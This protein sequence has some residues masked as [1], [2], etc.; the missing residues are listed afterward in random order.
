MGQIEEFANYL[1]EKLV[2]DDIEGRWDI[3]K[4]CEHLTAHNRCTQCGCFM[5]LKTKLKAARCPIGK[6]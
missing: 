5:K 3:C 2:S 4:A 6:W 1:K